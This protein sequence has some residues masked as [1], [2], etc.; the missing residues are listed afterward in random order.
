MSVIITEVELISA[1]MSRIPLF[2]SMFVFGENWWTRMD[3]LQMV[4]KAPFQLAS[5]QSS[6][7]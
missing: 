2:A 4:I 6:L 3:R 1:G 7:T 5:T